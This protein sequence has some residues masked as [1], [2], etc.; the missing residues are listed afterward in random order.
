MIDLDHAVF[1]EKWLSFL[2]RNP[3]V[4]AYTDPVFIFVIPTPSVAD[5]GLPALVALFPPLPGGGVFPLST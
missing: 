5:P 1:T 4:K 3:A 2:D